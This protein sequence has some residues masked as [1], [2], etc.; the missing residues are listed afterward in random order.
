M[1]FNIVCYMSRAEDQ[2]KEAGERMKTAAGKCIHFVLRLQTHQ[3]KAQWL[4][5]T[6]KWLQSMF[7][8]LD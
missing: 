8:S 6:Y 3:D 4:H 5:Y 2:E 1:F 7:T